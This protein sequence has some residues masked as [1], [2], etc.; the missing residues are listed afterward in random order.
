MADEPTLLYAHGV[1]ASGTSPD[2]ALERVA[3]GGVAALVSRV[4]AAEFG[5]EAL[6]ERLADP[7][8]LARA[9][10][11]HERV[12]EDVLRRATVVPFRF[13]TLYRSEGHLRAFLLQHGAEL[14]GLLER[15]DGK[16]ELGVKGFV[17]SERLRHAAS[18]AAEHEA[19]APAG[20]P[21]RA[22]LLQRRAE[23]DA[24][25]GS[26]RLA[27]AC[28]E[29]AHARLSAVA[30]DA[31]LNPTQPRELSGRD[32]EMLLN[33]AYLVRRDRSDLE[34]AVAGLNAAYGDVGFSFEITGPW[35]PYN[36]VDLA[37]EAVA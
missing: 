15:L 10:H 29:E 33:G 37:V 17:D 30:E 34:S 6:P 13:C 16:E 3:E 20:G 25:D 31:R 5:E 4:Q 9:I 24:A 32:E 27:A 1:V 12:L 23:R 26:E 28:V 21:G 7:D 8:W 18:S 35:P 14:R 11:R 19:A 2:A 22:Y 36:F